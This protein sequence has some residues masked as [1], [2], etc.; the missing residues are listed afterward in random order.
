MKLTFEI[1]YH[2]SEPG[3]YIVVVGNTPALGSGDPKKGA[4]M[5]DAGNGRHRLE[6]EVSAAKE[7]V[8]YRYAVCAA[9]EVVR[10][11]WGPD[12]TVR[13]DSRLQSALIVDHWKDIPSDKPFYST[14]MTECVFRRT[15]SHAVHSLKPSM[16][17]IEVEAAMIPNDTVLAIVGSEPEIGA[18][19]PDEAV[20]MT[21]TGMPYWKVQL[22]LEAFVGR[23]TEYKFILLS[24]QTGEVVGWETGQNRHI[25]IPDKLPQES[26]IISGLHFNNPLPLWHGAG[27]AIP[28]FSL[29]S[30]DDFG[31]GDF[32]DLKLMVD[33]AAET[34]QSVV[35]ILP[36]N[37]TTMTHTW[38]DCYPYNANSCFALHPMYLRLSEMGTLDD[39]SE[40]ARFEQIRLELNA[41]PT[42]DYEKVN[43][44]K[45]EYTR[46]LFALHGTSDLDTAE[47][48][49]FYKANSQWLKPYAAYCTLRDQYS[50]ANMGDWDEWAVYSP[51]RV[52]RL[53]R[54]KPEE[55]NY[56][57]YLQFHLDRQLRHVR[58][59]AHSKG[60]AIKGDIPIG[61]SRCS[62]DAW[63]MPE[64]FNLDCSAGAPPDD[65][66]VLGQNW[67]F[68][69]YRWDQM[70]RDGFLWWRR[71][72]EKMA[73][74]FDAY[75]IDHV[76]G[77]FRI[78]QIPVTAIHGLLGSFYSA[79]PLSPEEMLD[80][81]GFQFDRERMTRP[82][83]TEETLR[84]L[85]G[86]L[87]EM[88][89][90]RYLA[91]A[92]SGLYQLLPIVD[93]QMK[94]VT[95]VSRRSDLSPTELER[96]CQ[97]LLTIHDYVL[98][99]PDHDQP[100]LYHPRIAV[101]STPQ[102][103]TL[104]PEQQRAFRQLYE[105]FFYH[106]NDQLWQ[107]KAMEKL[108]PLIDATRMLCCAEDLGMIPACVPEV[109]DRL[110]I[111]SLEI[112]RMPKSFDQFA[113]PAHYPYLSVCSTS[114][115]DMSGIRGWWEEN[116][117]R[118]R[119][120]FYNMLNGSGESPVVATPDICRQI[121]ES[122]LRA[123]SMLC[124]FPL[125]DWLSIDQL[126]RRDNPADE[127]IN[128][129]SNSAHYWRYRLHIPLET[130]IAAS[131][132][133]ARIRSMIAASGR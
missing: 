66:S 93:N 88:V 116:L 33:W 97:G 95:E 55:F 115:H 107:R 24:E 20:L 35:Q 54:Q 13:F 11:E 119:C 10:Q 38:R 45:N 14:L 60:V 12:R 132:L 68:P 103:K 77:F 114:T 92:P 40:A 85:F 9:G 87:S 108:P 100:E 83:A 28:V 112:Q 102:F 43:S 59:Y 27:T 16:L 63:T 57:F 25:D 48:Q 99:I 89:K 39:T 46:K 121:L 49:T 58:D 75:R 72:L 105:D 37:D 71:R 73:E 117:E 110:R 36:I 30:N 18:W 6:I 69:T 104:N 127:Q 62:V 128:E 98:F 26:M 86:D 78:W 118:S 8:G 124:I 96:L 81:Y 1:E 125:Q 44:A 3:Q 21:S 23:H 50:T 17:Q 19:N 34:G 47:F 123:P 126:L 109:M 80:R 31:V 82:Y 56:V 15:D 22:P 133:N 4:I 5:T 67:G 41:M 53:M 51:S 94:V 129:P 2:I 74:Y 79:L 84:I 111:L 61:I 29:R 101:F 130:L 65:F 52:D 131:D 64:L 113:D 120:Y 70:A 91:P 90:E 122:N 106:R 32:Y 7:S 42:V 76:L